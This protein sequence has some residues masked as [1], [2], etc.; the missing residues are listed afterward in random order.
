MEDIA[1]TKEQVKATAHDSAS[2]DSELYKLGAFITAAFAGAVGIWSLICL[3]S[4]LISG[5]GPVALVKSMFSAIVG[6]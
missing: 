6:S 1:I 3:S 2:T 5:D 4:A